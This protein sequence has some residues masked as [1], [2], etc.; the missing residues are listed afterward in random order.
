MGKF[1]EESSVVCNWLRFMIFY[2]IQQH[3]HSNRGRRRKRAP[4]LCDRF[5]SVFPDPYSFYT[6]PAWDLNTN[7][8]PVFFYTGTLPEILNIF[9]N[10]RYWILKK[11]LIR[12][13]VPVPYR[14]LNL[15][16]QGATIKYLYCTVYFKLTNTLKFWH[17]VV[18]FFSN[19]DPDPYSEYGPGSRALLIPMNS[20]IILGLV[21]TVPVIF[22]SLVLGLAPPCSSPREEVSDKRAAAAADDSPAVRSSPLAAAIRSVAAGGNEGAGVLRSSRQPAGDPASRNEDDD[23]DINIEDDADLKPAADSEDMR[24]AP[25]TATFSRFSSV[26]IGGGNAMQADGRRTK[27]PP[28][29]PAAAMPD[30]GPS[31]P[32]PTSSNV[33]SSFQAKR[34]LRGRQVSKSKFQRLAASSLW[35]FSS[36]L[37][38]RRFSSWSVG[39][40]RARFTLGGGGGLLWPAGRRVGESSSLDE[41]RLEKRD[42]N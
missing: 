28:L 42:N 23:D 11:W 9:Y 29:L 13:T 4:P 6:V 38:K 31:A 7:P 3:G 25:P 36:W 5:W 30:G 12:K 18:F 24:G 37:T 2:W 10:D 41:L 26:S 21:V 14:Y 1:S 17:F 8:E 22:C 20:N 16:P 19:L 39:P 15:M 33:V 27:M 35:R 32:P 40:K 34:P